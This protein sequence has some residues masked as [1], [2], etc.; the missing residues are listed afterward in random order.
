MTTPALDPADALR[1]HQ[2]AETACQLLKALANTDRLILLCQ[3]AE[4][5]LNV[6]ELETRTGISQPTLSQQLAVLR[7]EELVETRREGKQV[8]YRI[9]SHQALAVIETLYR[10]FC[11]E[12]PR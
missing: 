9:A 8:Y 10:L 6:G 3:L 1:L 11:A 4:G 12:Q 2:S 5:E 7:R